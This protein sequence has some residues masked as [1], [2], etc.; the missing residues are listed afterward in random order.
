M[1]IKVLNY[2][3]KGVFWGSTIFIFNVI[4]LDKIGASA[5]YLLR[6]NL[7]FQAI[8]YLLFGIALSLSQIILE[9]ERLANAKKIIIHV[10]ILVCSVLFVG[11]IFGWISIKSPISIFAYILQFA[12][13][14][15]VIWIAQ[16]FYEKHQI[17]EFNN[18]LKNRDM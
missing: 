4:L 9:S 13:T 11:F 3:L 8:G 2:L 15:I 10:L 14:Y 7:A 16:Y 17:K 6:D 1:V 5:I 12:I 18:A